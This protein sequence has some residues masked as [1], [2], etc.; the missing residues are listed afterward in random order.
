MR[1]LVADDSR[2]EL[3]RVRQIITAVG[4]EVVCE[5]RDGF[6]AVNALKAGLEADLCILDVVMPYMSGDAAAL[7]IFERFPHMKIVFAT[8]NSQPALLEIIE[9]VG[10]RIVVK[11]YTEKNLAAALV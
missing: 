11:P 3:A 2:V 8:K 6:A 7:A 10:A 5:V 1:V 4:H 9:R